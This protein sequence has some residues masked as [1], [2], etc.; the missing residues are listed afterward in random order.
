MALP[1]MNPPPLPS[2]PPGGRLLRPPPARPGVYRFDAAAILD[3]TGLALAP[4]SML[5]E[6]AAGPALHTAEPPGALPVAARF[7]ILAVDTP[8]QV[9]THPAARAAHRIHLPTS[10][11]L[12]PFVNAHAHLDLTHIGP[13]AHDSR[14]G[15]VGFVDLV[16]GE[17]AQTD[18]DIAASVL[19]GAELSLRAGVVAVGDIAGAPRGEP[20]FT[21][22]RALATTPLSGVSFIEFFGIGKGETRG[23]ERLDQIVAQAR[24][25]QGE[26]GDG[27]RIGLQP[28]AT[29]TIS[30]RL[31]A[32]AAQLAVEA[33]LP[34]CT[35][36]AET[37]EE[38]EFIA[39]A[40]GP[41]RELLERLGV[42][43][44]GLLADIGLSRTPVEHLAGVLPAARWLAVHVN[45]CGDADLELLARAGVTIAYC[46]R[47]SAYFGAECVFGAHRY[48]DLLKAGVPV[49]LGTD[50]IINLPVGVDAP[51]GPGL[52]IL[53]EM[54]FLHRRDR[55]DP[56]IL[57]AMGTTTAARALNG[58][59]GPFRFVN[60]GLPAGLVAVEVGEHRPTVASML[61]ADTRPLLLL[62]RN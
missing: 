5:I 35:H 20:Q 47:A 54:R 24:A 34:I 61:E 43:E 56:L 37:P 30:P 11:L 42:W 31:Y 14:A 45:D 10:V 21:P 27:L 29:N 15:F 32:R 1:R 58:D 52:S 59:D 33:G 18:A 13:R 12:P 4:G 46:P 26:L 3:A 16:R 53:E 9:D 39:R 57:L 7:T 25:M 48:R 49:A 62:V 60:G 50:S 55:V 28:H 2:P 40:R 17:R 22:A 19:R 8:A 23:F 44:D 36:L 6:I 38:R 51:D 41:Q